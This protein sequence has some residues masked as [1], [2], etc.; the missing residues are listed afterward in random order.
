MDD[1]QAFLA[2]NPIAPS[3][4]QFLP[5]ER[6]SDDKLAAQ[7][8]FFGQHTGLDT[9]VDAVPDVYLVLNAERQIVFANERMRE[10]IDCENFDDIA[11]LRVGEALDCVHSDK[12]LGGCGTTEFCQ[13]CGAALAILTSQKGKNDVRECRIMQKNG[14]AL[15]LRVWTTPTDIEE[16]RYTIFSVH[17]IADEKRR[18]VLERIFFHDILN[19]AG[20]L[21]GI[22]ELLDTASPEELADLH[23][24]ISGVAVKLVDEI[25]AQRD[26]AAAE[27]NELSLQQNIIHTHEFLQEMAN[28]YL[29]HPVADGKTIVVSEKTADA[30]LITDKRLLGRVLGNMIKNAFEAVSD[31]KTVTIGC[32]ANGEEQVRFWVHNPTTMPK[33]VQLQ[34]FQ[35][36]FSTKGEGRGLGTYSIKLLTERYM[37]GKVWFTTDKM[38]GT[39]FFVEYPLQHRL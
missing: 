28:L 32:D 29:T 22:S 10:W 13:T 25:Q 39:T 20:V 27:A 37:G 6:A 1:L 15:D 30:A 33:H 21:Q 23:T 34:I 35:R 9:F 16:T 8:W 19:T 36:S 12:T 18:R 4:T 17:N 11:G 26:L 3:E 24:L 31:D 5:A 14:N 38:D 2:A 7:V